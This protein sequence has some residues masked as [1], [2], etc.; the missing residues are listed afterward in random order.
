[1]F[2]NSSLEKYPNG[3][4]NQNEADTDPVKCITSH[5]MIKYCTQEPLS[6]MHDSY[7]SKTGTENPHGCG[8]INVICTAYVH[9]LLPI[10]NDICLAGMLVASVLRC[11]PIIY[12]FGWSTNVLVSSAYKQSL[13]VFA[14]QTILITITH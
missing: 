11:S 4:V 7:P 5:V 10:L 12:T 9:G 8:K 2:P 6:L 13:G 3:P 1:M 14:G